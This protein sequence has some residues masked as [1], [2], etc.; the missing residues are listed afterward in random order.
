MK[1]QGPVDSGIKQD[2]AGFGFLPTGAADKILDL[3]GYFRDRRAVY[4]P[5]TLIVKDRRWLQTRHVHADGMPFD[6]Q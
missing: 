4:R 2:G 3:T 1:L 6:L 5:L